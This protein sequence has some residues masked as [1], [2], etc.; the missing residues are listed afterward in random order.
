MLQGPGSLHKYYTIKQETLKEKTFMN[1]SLVPPKDTSPKDDTS[2][3]F[4]V[5][6]LPIATNLKIRKTF[7]PQKFHTVH[8]Q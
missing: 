2:P 3:K 8:V 6:I 5:N 4:G 7:P 1:Y